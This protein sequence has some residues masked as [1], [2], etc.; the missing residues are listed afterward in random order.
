[1]EELL[2]SLGYS[3]FELIAERFY[4][5]VYRISPTGRVVK[6][7]TAHRDLRPEGFQTKSEASHFGAEMFT[8]M[9]KLAKL[10]VPIPSISETDLSIV[11]DRSRGKPFAVLNVPDAGLSVG[12]L[13]EHCELPSLRELA[14][15]MICA[16][17]PVFY[18]PC[19]VS[20]GYPEVGIDSTA[21]NFTLRDSILAYVDF[22]APRYYSP[23]RGYRIEYP[24]PDSEVELRQG[25]WQYYSFCGII[26]R[27]L[28]DCCRIRPDGRGI[29][30]DVLTECLPHE[31]WRSAKSQLYSLRLPS[32]LH[33]PDW[34]IAIRGAGLTDLRDLAC[35]VA[36]GDGLDPVGTKQWL[37]DF[38]TASRHHPGQPISQERLDSLRVNLLNRF[39]SLS[40]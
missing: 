19:I 11:T 24:Q 35:A 16:L 39:A 5:W 40:G 22:T 1:M 14:K 28:N 13:L 7:S 15:E 27:W 12:S 21:S 8:Y 32:D 26:T 9:E 3:D 36:F 37:G 30:L 29:F 2:R 4:S 33:A 34:R 31:I 17:L 6:V 20:G 38:Y 23:N 10:G 18:Q 25:R